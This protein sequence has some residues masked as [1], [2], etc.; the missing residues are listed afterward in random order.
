MTVAEILDLALMEKAKVGRPSVNRWRGSLLGGCIRQQWYSTEGVTPT[1]PFPDSL[2]RVFERGHVVADVLNRA[3][4][5]AETQGLLVSFRE[6]VPI[7][8]NEKN[9]SGNADAV[10]EWPNGI[11]EVWEYK[12]INSRGMQY[13]KGVKPEHAIQAS[14]YA[15]VLEMQSG[16]PHE[17]RVVYV[18]ADNFQI[19]E[20][21][22]D[23]E[24]RNRAMRILNVLNYYGKR[25]PPRLPSRRGKDMKAEWP[26]K[27]CQWLKECRG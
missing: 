12:S 14:I 6:E 1:N 21:K 18:A 24:W 27:G 7:L 8:W 2:Y 11:K 3:G 15:H 19:V 17:A 23:R 4:L 10:V 22:L 5:L 13:L 25:K 26:C 20:Y 9:F 16:D